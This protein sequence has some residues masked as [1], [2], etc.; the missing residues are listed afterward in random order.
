MKEPSLLTIE[1]PSLSPGKVLRRRRIEIDRGTGRILR[2][3]E[4]EGAAEILLDDHFLVLPGLIDLHV[5][6]R[7]DA[8]GRQSYK[9]D[10]SSA[11]AA[12][13]H[14]GVT[15][16][17]DMPNN[18]FPPVDDGSYL[19]KRHLA[20]RAPVDVLLLAGIGPRTRPLSF[21]VP[22]KVFMGP[23]IGDLYFETES[24][25]REALGRYRERWVAFHAEAPEILNRFR[26][27]PTHAER[28]PPEAESK[29]VRLALELARQSSLLAH[30]CHLSTEA[31]LE[32]IRAARARGMTVTCEV[33]PHH[34]FFDLEDLGRQRRPVF[35]QC[36][37]PLRP[38][39]D[40]LALLEALRK[41]E[42]D[43]IA[44]DHAPHSLEENLK[45]ISGIPHLD[46]FGPFLTHLAANGVP[47]EILCRAAS[48]APGRIL[49]EYLGEPYGAIE[50]GAVGS[51]TVLD[52]SRPLEVRAAGLR[53]RAAWSPFEGIT[54]PGSVSHTIV[55][56]KVHAIGNGA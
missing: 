35:L 50:E 25:L 13:I 1:G 10:F 16:F 52:L 23:S 45:G 20:R 47:W 32:E 14:G 28:R 4:P 38:R 41:G 37:P 5:H 36:N 17:A 30:I 27:Q 54:F 6:A 7:E 22:Y 55:R 53:S 39:S 43:C 56:G 3:T 12:A 31:G 21:P 29:A 15:A 48:G 26:D 2:V 11:G 44:S 46:T 8:S 24:S 18:P 34:L 33:S 40:R 9:E 42:I 49:T 51:L 19:E